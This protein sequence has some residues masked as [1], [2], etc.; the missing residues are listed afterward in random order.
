MFWSDWGS[1][2]K[3]EAA[4]LDGS[5]RITIAT[6]DLR[7]PNGLAIDYDRRLL[8]WVDAEYDVIEFANFDGRYKS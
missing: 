5:Q 2:P 1:L 3:I 8:F 4:A 7:Y 6:E